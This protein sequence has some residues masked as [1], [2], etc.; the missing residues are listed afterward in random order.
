MSE[1]LQER[2]QV[3]SRG[4]TDWLMN[5][6]NEV[7][8]ENNTVKKRKIS[9]NSLANLKFIKKRQVL[10]PLGAGARTEEQKIAIRAR[11]EIRKIAKEAVEKAESMA[12]L[13]APAAI[14]QTWRL[15]RKDIK[16]QRVQLDA[17][18]V[19]LSVAGLMG[20]KGNMGVAV[21]VNFSDKIKQRKQELQNEENGQE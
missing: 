18:K 9:P 7:K 15:S 8:N 1:E 20:Q 19:I 6:D 13:R 12:Q 3:E 11:H 10:N 5:N 16:D 17:N 2:N 4:I 14:R 21:Q